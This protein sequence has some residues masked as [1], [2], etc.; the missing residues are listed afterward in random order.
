MTQHHRT[1]AKPGICANVQCC[2]S[3]NGKPCGSP[4]CGTYLS[5]SPIPHRL[6]L[7]ATVLSLGSPEASAVGWRTSDLN[8]DWP[9]WPHRTTCF[10]IQIPQ[11]PC[12]IVID[13]HVCGTLWIPSLSSRILREFA[14]LGTVNFNI[15]SGRNHIVLHP[16][17]Q[18][19]SLASRPA[20][21]LNTCRR[22]AFL[23]QI[24]SSLQDLS[25]T[26]FPI[27]SLPRQN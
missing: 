23:R 3:R 4:G 25:A 21:F 1:E 27:S 15:C 20:F 14:P 8:L 18:I 5:S 22:A 9:H 17:R 13:S 2:D 16:G 19:G 11:H 12:A 6:H 26:I 10:V 24:E 7:M